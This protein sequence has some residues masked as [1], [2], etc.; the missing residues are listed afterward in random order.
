MT[1]WKTNMYASGMSATYWRELKVPGISASV[2]YF[3]TNTT[4]S[5]YETNPIIMYETIRQSRTTQR[6]YCDC[7]YQSHQ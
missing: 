4:L 2:P 1:P 3:K 6:L 5:S 7:A